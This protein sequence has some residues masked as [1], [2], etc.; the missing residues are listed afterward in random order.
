MQFCA[1]IFHFI[2]TTKLIAMLFR[3]D[4]NFPLRMNCY[5]NFG[6]PF[7]KIPSTCRTNDIY[8]TFGFACKHTKQQKICCSLYI[9]LS[10][11]LALPEMF[12]TIFKLREVH[13]FLKGNGA[14]VLVTCCYNF[15]E[16]QRVRIKSAT[17][18]KCSTCETLKAYLRL[19]HFLTWVR[20]VHQQ[21]WLF[22]NEDSDSHDPVLIMYLVLF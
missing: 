16:D 20:L 10:N 11:V 1:D 14:S 21:W 15:R 19:D 17:M 5:D 13:H 22:N 18:A 7:N 9:F 8:F 12:T 2:P 4:I 6:G 3:L